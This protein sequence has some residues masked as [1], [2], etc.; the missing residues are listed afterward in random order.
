MVGERL[1]STTAGPAAATPPAK[2]LPFWWFYYRKRFS[3]VQSVQ[4]KV[5]NFAQIAKILQTLKQKAPIM[6]V[7]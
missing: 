1:K 3:N 5:F 4:E 2:I 6:S 7:K